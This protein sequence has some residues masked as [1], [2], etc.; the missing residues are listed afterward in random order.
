[1]NMQNVNKAKKIMQ[2]NKVKSVNDA[3]IAEQFGLAG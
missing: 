2:N 1:M 3:E